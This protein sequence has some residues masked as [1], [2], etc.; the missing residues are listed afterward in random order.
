[1]VVND[2]PFGPGPE[3]ALDGNV[4]VPPLL[5][6]RPLPLV[7]TTLSGQ[8]STRYWSIELEY[9]YRTEQRHNGEYFEFFAGPRYFEFDDSFN[10]SATGGILGDSMWDTNTENHVIAGQVGARWF[11]KVGRWMLNAEGRFWAGL[12]CQNL[13]EQGVLA[14][15][16]NPGTTATGQPILMAP[17]AFEHSVFE[18]EFNPGVELRLEARYQLTRAISMR[19][20]WTGMW[21]DRVARA[22]GLIDYSVQRAAQGLPAGFDILPDRNLQNMWANGLTFGIDIN[23]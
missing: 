16:A 6:V 9:I 20:G 2:P 14:T 21:M 17:T 18:R 5:L 13:S 8:N 11:R 10:V 22:S 19:V 1:M 7:W 4:L 12:N 23:R 15:F 3:R